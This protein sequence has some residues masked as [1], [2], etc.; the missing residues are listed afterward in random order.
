M[1]D[2]NTFL[3]NGDSVGT[4]DVAS[5]SLARHYLSNSSFPNRHVDKVASSK[6]LHFVTL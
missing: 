4:M 1:P 3:A 6:S 2:N 5:L